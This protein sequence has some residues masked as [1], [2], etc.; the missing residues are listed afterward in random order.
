SI[1]EID[2]L[3]IAILFFVAAPITLILKMFEYD[4]AARLVGMRARPRAALDVAVVSSAANLLPLPGS[5]LVTAHSLSVRGATYGEAAVASTIP[6]LSW[7]T[8]S[9]LI[10][11]VCVVIAGSSFVG[12][13]LALGGAVLAGVTIVMFHRSAPAHGRLLLGLRILV[14]ETSWV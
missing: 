14:I 4:A 9:L 8:I 6:S 2:W 3:A 5:L 11:G 10:G 7:L 13:A 1:S 12:A